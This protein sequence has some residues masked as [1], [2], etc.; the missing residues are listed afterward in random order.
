MTFSML[1]MD[2]QRRFMVAASATRTL[3]VGA[4]VI[5]LRA[6]V[7]GVL[8]QA[9][10]NPELREAGLEAMSNDQPA[11]SA[12]EQT[13]AKDNDMET[14]QVAL[15]NFKGETAV[16][17]GKD[18]LSYAGGLSESGLAIVGNLLSGPEVISSMKAHFRDVEGFHDLGN[19]TLEM[20]MAGENSGG[21]SRGLQSAAILIRDMSLSKSDFSAAEI[22]IR[23]DDHSNPLGEL[24]RVLKLALEA[25]K[26]KLL[27]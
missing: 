12:L 22:D 1:A 10:T 7:G 19:L 2:K 11:A 17:T 5:A 23:V 27:T 9:L 13:L 21:D 25:Q 24:D 3:S 8:S 4:N 20:M 16:H 15:M 14:R 26:P 6:R 18:C